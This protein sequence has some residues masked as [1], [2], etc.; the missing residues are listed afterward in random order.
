M[1]YRFTAACRHGRTTIV[2]LRCDQQQTD[3]GTLE[4]PSKCPD[5][6]CDGCVFLFLWRS[7]FA[8]PRCRK[9]S[10]TEVV[11]ECSAGKQKVVRI[12]PK[13][14]FLRGYLK[15]VGSQKPKKIVPDPKMSEFSPECLI[16]V[17]SGAQCT[18]HYPTPYTYPLP[19]IS[20]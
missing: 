3:N 13:Y 7:Q 16:Q 10:F 1:W 19:V 11:E 12:K 4:L 14:N 6:T 18:K 5:G 2:S 17:R 20:D 9:D 15:S 8:C